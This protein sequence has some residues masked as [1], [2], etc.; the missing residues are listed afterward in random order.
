MGQ[1]QHNAVKL[2]TRCTVKTS[3]QVQRSYGSTG[4]RF[5][6]LTGVT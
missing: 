2:L 6:D 5:K 1:N 3:A 4:Q